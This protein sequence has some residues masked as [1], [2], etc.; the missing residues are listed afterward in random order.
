MGQNLRRLPII[1]IAAVALLLC[2]VA[3]PRAWAGLYT[4]A[5]TKCLVQSSDSNDHGMLVQW[6]FAALSL[7][8]MV[9]PMS[10]V[11]PQQREDANKKVE[12]LFSRLLTYDCRAQALDALKYEGTSAVGASFRVLGQVAARDLMSNSHVAKGIDQL[13]VYFAA[14]DKFRELL[15]AAGL[16]K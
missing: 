1:G 4:D 14:D 10:A 3:T 6:M 7:H 12:A 16:N 11:T 5:L 13:G 9:A 2:G 15:K 8:P